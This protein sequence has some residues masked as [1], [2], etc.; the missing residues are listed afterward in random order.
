VNRVTYIFSF[1]QKLLDLRLAIIMVGETRVCQATHNGWCNAFVVRSIKAGEVQWGRRVVVVV[2][3][4]FFIYRGGLPM[5]NGKAPR[6]VLLQGY[7]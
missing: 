1:T 2:V 3:E 5:G 4:V 6:A 7:Y